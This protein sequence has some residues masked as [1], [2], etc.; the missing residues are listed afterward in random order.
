MKHGRQLPCLWCMYHDLSA[1]QNSLF[2]P[3]RGLK[4]EGCLFIKYQSRRRQTCAMTAAMYTSTSSATQINCSVV[5][6]VGMDLPFV[7]HVCGN[8]GNALQPRRSA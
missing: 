1:M 5:S 8:V 4:S 7:T 6:G 3:Q 2:Q